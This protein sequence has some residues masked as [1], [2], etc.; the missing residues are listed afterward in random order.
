VRISPWI[1]AVGAAA[2]ALLLMP[3]AVHTALGAPAEA[4][5][6]P[7]FT[8]AAGD[9][10]NSPPLAW[11]QL[12]GSVTLLEF[13]T[14]AC[15]NCERTIPWLQTLEPRY[16]SRGLRIV[17]V[18]TPELPREYVRGNVVRKVAELGVRWPVMLDNDY[19]YWKALHNRYWPAFYLVDRAGR[20][21][22]SFAGETHTGDANAA[23]MEQ[24][25]EALLREK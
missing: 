8:G 12:R 1:F 5:P 22:A 7:A 9:W 25:I 23:A 3:R 16:G 20:V 17:G 19:V 14:F 24:A 13:W 2:G 4:P 18:H 10:L 15:W 6:A 21:R 11:E